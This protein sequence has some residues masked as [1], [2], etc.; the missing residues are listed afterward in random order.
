MNIVNYSSVRD[1]QSILGANKLDNEAE[2]VKV[3]KEAIDLDFLS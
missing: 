3:V 2:S 1:W